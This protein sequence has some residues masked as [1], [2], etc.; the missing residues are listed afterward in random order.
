MWKDC[1]F[2]CCLLILVCN[3]MAYVSQTINEVYGV[4]VN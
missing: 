3:K 2:G 1:M 4:T